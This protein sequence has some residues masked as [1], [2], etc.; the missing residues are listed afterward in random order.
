MAFLKRKLRRSTSTTSIDSQQ[1][2]VSV[3]SIASNVSRVS[4]TP[5]VAD[6]AISTTSSQLDEHKFDAYL[7]FCANQ[8]PAIEVYTQQ[9]GD[10]ARFAEVMAQCDAKVEESGG[11]DLPSFLLKGM[12]RLLKYQPLLENALRATT[13]EKREEHRNLQKAIE[14]MGKVAFKV[15][16]AVRECE[17]ARRLPVLE[18]QLVVESLRPWVGRPAFD[19]NLSSDPTRR[20]LLEGA[21]KLVRPVLGDERRLLDVH[22]ILVSDML[23]VTVEKEGRYCLR[24]TK[25][26][27][28]VI[29]LNNITDIRGEITSSTRERTT[30]ML[31]VGSAAREIHPPP[32]PLL[33][34][35]SPRPVVRS[36]QRR[37]LR[38]EAATTTALRTW[39]VE[40]L[41]AR[42]AVRTKYAELQRTQ[43]RNSFALPDGDFAV[44]LLVSTTFED[45]GSMR[46][47]GI[48][49]VQQQVPDWEISFEQGDDGEE[50]PTLV[51][52]TRNVR[53]FQ[54][55][56]GLGMTLIGKNPVTIQ[57]VEKDGP[58]YAAGLREGD[59]IR[60]VNGEEC[61]SLSHV[62]VI[63]LIREALLSQRR[64]W[65]PVERPLDPI[66]DI[67]G[68]EIVRAA[69]TR[70][71]HKTK[72][73]T[74]LMEI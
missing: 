39:V 64:D 21:L 55:Q 31:E 41:R 4:V 3:S 36:P 51:E 43:S 57:E 29:K 49:H 11:F 30:L 45:D 70:G 14:R 10:N 23:L 8:T 5:K 58:A 42:E 65:H 38:F 44:T 9:K 13:P 66:P 62:E 20:L 16:E 56:D 50:G 68:G 7:T 72:K 25:D 73:M 67:E 27:V 53:V 46:A 63:H 34:R 71:P 54:G 59:A 6:D 24:E 22:A 48:E 69:H 2:Q 60:A 17:N 40:L 61:T 35:D 28:P 26:I 33:V 37:T 18:K 47:A 12:Q 32:S 19:T 52:T 74:F 1:S 15:N